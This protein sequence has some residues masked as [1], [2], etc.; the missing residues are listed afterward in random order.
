[1]ILDKEMGKNMIMETQFTKEIIKM[2]KKMD[3]VNI[4]GLMAIHIKVNGRMILYLEKEFIL[5]Q[6]G[7]YIKDNGKTI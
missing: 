5:S 6:M 7:G 3:L 2:V 1:M 4:F